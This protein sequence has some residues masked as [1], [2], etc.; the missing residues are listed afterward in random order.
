[1][2]DDKVTM[3]RLCKLVRSGPEVGEVMANENGGSGAGQKEACRAQRAARQGHKNGAWGRGPLLLSGYREEKPYYLYRDG[4]APAR[5]KFAARP[6]VLDSGVARRAG[7]PH[8]SLH[9]SSLSAQRDEQG[10]TRGQG[11]ESGAIER[12]AAAQ[13]AALAPTGAPGGIPLGLPGTAY[14]VRHGEQGEAEAAPVR[15]LEEERR[16]MRADV[17]AAVAQATIRHRAG[18]QAGSPG[19]D[20]PPGLLAGTARGSTCAAHGA[21]QM[22][23]VAAAGERWT[24]GRGR[25]REAAA[26]RDPLAAARLQ[27]GQSGGPSPATLRKVAAYLARHGVGQE[28]PEVAAMRL[29]LEE[30]TAAIL[31]LQGVAASHRS[32]VEALEEGAHTSERREAQWP[33]LCGERHASSAPAR[34]L[35]AAF[36]DAAAGSPA[37][38]VHSDLEAQAEELWSEVHAAQAEAAVAR[39]A[40]AA[41]AAMPGAAVLGKKNPDRSAIVEPAAGCGQSG[42]D[43]AGAKL[44]AAEAAVE[45]G[46]DVAGAEPAVVEP[47]RDGDADGTVAAE[48]VPAGAEADLE[49]TAEAA[50][51]VAQAAVAIEER[52]SSRQGMFFEETDEEYARR[53]S[54]T[55]TKIEM[56]YRELCNIFK[57]TAGLAETQA[58][59]ARRWSGGVWKEGRDA[60]KRRAAWLSRGGMTEPLRS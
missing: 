6:I 50:A 60:L 33:R 10:G 2:R 28:D 45:P 38:G 55:G 17:V 15:C 39:M 27:A 26:L 25:V 43:A 47:S 19:G 20:S 59:R 12:S 9:A 5:S 37:I 14:T 46:Q 31:R 22:G 36:D 8:A 48:A 3:Q 7:A 11:L 21:E 52:R 29:Q 53:M 4:T 54:A 51:A 23:P 16:R 32:R 13:A 56:E 18:R 24:D 41:P 1:M 40:V 30:A 58:E 34:N 49:L 35:Q 57:R 44:E 42:Q